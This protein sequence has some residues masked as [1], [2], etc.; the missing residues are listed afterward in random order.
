MHSGPFRS[1]T[2]PTTQQF[3]QDLTEGYFPSELK[4]R[5]PNGVP[6]QVSVAVKEVLNSVV[7]YISMYVH[8]NKVLK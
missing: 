8:M 5:Y 4:Q 1:Y 6:F 2:D 3:V 7:S